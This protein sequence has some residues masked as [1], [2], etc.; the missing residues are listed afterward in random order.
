MNSIAILTTHA[1]YLERVSVVV[2]VHTDRHLVQ[3]REVSVFLRRAV[4][5]QQDARRQVSLLGRVDA[6][7]DT[8][9]SQIYI[10][11]IYIYS[12]FFMKIIILNDF[13]NIV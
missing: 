13:Y 1:D 10:Y 2:N 3:R 9:K 4:L 12:F 6:R 11:I 8:G 5:A 7:S